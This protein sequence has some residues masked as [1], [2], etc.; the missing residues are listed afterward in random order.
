M[1]FKCKNF[2]LTKSSYCFNVVYEFSPD[3]RLD[4]FIKLK[5]NAEERKFSVAI[6]KIC[7]SEYPKEA[8]RQFGPN[9]EIG[10]K[11]EVPPKIDITKSFGETTRDWG[12]GARGQSKLVV[13]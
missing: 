2:A 6:V 4:L 10:A 3:M 13:A 5:R 12:G 1:K 9:T 11:Y 8:T 7:I